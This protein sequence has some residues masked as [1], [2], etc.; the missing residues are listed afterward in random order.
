MGAPPPVPHDRDLARLYREA[1][2]DQRDALAGI[3]GTGDFLG[4]HMTM[5]DAPSAI[6]AA[7]VGFT[8]LDARR[9]GDDALADALAPIV[10]HLLDAVGCRMAL[11][12]GL[13]EVGQD[14]DQGAGPDPHAA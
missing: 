13:A 12:A 9:R 14:P 5:A 4:R 2:Q 8:F 10:G 1:P 11:I 6:V 7:W 3:L